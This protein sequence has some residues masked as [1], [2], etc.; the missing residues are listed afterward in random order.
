MQ[1]LSDY[2]AIIFDMDGT[3]HDTEALLNNADREAARILGYRMSQEILLKL[4]GTNNQS[5][6]TVLKQVFG[7]QFPVE[8]FFLERDKLVHE[9]KLTAAI[10]L[11]PG[12][13][14]VLDWCQSLEIPCAVATST[15]HAKAERDLAHTGIV[16]YF[17]VIVGGDMVDNGKPAPDIFLKTAGLLDVEPE[18]CVVIEDSYNGIRAA[19]AARMMPVMIPDGLPCTEEMERLAHAVFGTLTEFQAYLAGLR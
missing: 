9:A 6:A 19:H 5:A 7:A 4:I 11:K 3:L 10:P 18:S 17:E 16:R 12:A 13:R 15:A 14:E 1:R 2:S 8:R